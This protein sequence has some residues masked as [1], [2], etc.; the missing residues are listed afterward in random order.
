[1]HIF[2]CRQ[3]STC[4]EGPW[5]PQDTWAQPAYIAGNYQMLQRVCKYMCYVNEIAP[6]A[7]SPLMNH[8]LAS[9]RLASWLPEDQQLV[10]GLC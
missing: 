8:V 10:Q 9:W 5:A 1:M 2:G 3:P 6:G 4:V 7:R